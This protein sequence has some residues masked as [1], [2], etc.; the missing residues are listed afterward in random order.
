[1]S[2]ATT[3]FEPGYGD[4]G[5]WTQRWPFFIGSASWPPGAADPAQDGDER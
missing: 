3:T 2:C 4:T 5:T 1:M